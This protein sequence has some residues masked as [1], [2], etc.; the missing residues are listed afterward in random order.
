[1]MSVRQ[2]DPGEAEDATP[3][4]SPVYVQDTSGGQNPWDFNCTRVAFA[5]GR[6]NRSKDNLAVLR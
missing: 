3:A 1:M 6:S 2:R 4:S 5:R